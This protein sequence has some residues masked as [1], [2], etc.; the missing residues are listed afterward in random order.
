MSAHFSQ[1]FLRMRSD[2]Q[3]PD[4]TIILSD[5][6]VIL[7]HL[8]GIHWTWS[9]NEGIIKVNKERFFAVITVFPFQVNFLYLE[10]VWFGTF[11]GQLI[12]FRMID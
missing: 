3:F 4:F 12:L 5:F 11:N 1:E 10:I 6:E 7:I 9:E 2:E 8:W